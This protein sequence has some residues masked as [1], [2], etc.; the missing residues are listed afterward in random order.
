VH[1]VG[2][3][4]EMG[5]ACGAYGLGEGLYGVLMGKPDGKDHRGNLR[6]DGW[7]ILGRIF[8]TWGVGIW[9]VFACLK[10]ETVGGRL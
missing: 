7:I 3:I 1:L 10:I 9:T 2:F 6:A 4:I 5:W 8:R